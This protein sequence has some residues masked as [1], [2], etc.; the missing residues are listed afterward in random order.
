M[1]IHI[2]ARPQTPR[3]DLG[4]FAQLRARQIKPSFLEKRPAVLEIAPKR[5]LTQVQIKAADLVPHAH[6]RRRHMHRNGRFASAALF[7]PDDNNMRHTPAPLPHLPV[8]C[9]ILL[10]DTIC[11]VT[12]FGKWC[13]WNVWSESEAAMPRVSD[14]DHMIG[15]IYGFVMR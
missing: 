5:P 12:G 3:L 1:I 13:E 9:R 14:E 8:L 6:K 2:L 4:K 10:S 15:S 11:G 7:V